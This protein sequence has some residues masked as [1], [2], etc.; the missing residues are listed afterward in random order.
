MGP[1]KARAAKQKAA[2]QEREEIEGKIAELSRAWPAVTSRRARGMM[3]SFNLLRLTSVSPPLRSRK[4]AKSKTMGLAS[5]EAHLRETL[6]LRQVPP[7]ER[8][9]E[10]MT[11]ALSKTLLE[12][13]LGS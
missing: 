2:K 6:I 5:P 8:G 3:S 12:M 4:E 13:L 9:R 1:S 10:Q 11:Q 7:R